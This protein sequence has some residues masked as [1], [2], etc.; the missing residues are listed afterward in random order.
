MGNDDSM[1]GA[2]RSRSFALLLT[3]FMTQHATLATAAAAAA[4]A[5]SLHPDP[6]VQRHR[7]SR[8]VRRRLRSI[9]LDD[10]CKVRS[11]ADGGG[12][13]RGSDVGGGREGAIFHPLHLARRIGDAIYVLVSGAKIHHVDQ[14]NRQPSTRFA[15]RFPTRETADRMYADVSLY[16]PVKFNHDCAG[17]T[18]P[19][20][21]FLLPSPTNSTG[22]VVGVGDYA[23]DR[24]GWPDAGTKYRSDEQ[25]REEG[26]WRVLR[27]RK[28][29]GYGTKCYEEVR[30][31]VLDWEFGTVHG[32]PDGTGESRSKASGFRRP[33][34]MG[35]I[36]ARHVFQP[37][38]DTAKACSFDGPNNQSQN[39][40]RGE[41]MSKIIGSTRHATSRSNE[42]PISS[43]RA[44]D[45]HLG[46]GGRRMVTYT[47][48]RYGVDIG[49]FRIGLPSFYAVSPVAGVYELVDKR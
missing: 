6:Y 2:S 13:C 29:V 24:Y 36:R 39:I 45:I 33:R 18:R 46:P 4:G 10:T 23:L 48:A 42:G 9:Y 27:Y 21:G 37:A 34:A 22:G 40:R 44:Q 41:D 25:A 38:D 15:F 30:R 28:C 49:R 43:P 1:M 12:H 20:N 14:M 7:D 35:I 8:R 32:E 16:N 31:A 5:V 47:E 3:L 17:M 19:R 26:G 11:C